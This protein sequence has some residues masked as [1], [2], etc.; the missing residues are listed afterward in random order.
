MVAYRFTM[1]A[2]AIVASFLIL[3]RQRAN[4]KRQFYYERAFKRGCL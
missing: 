2:L 3:I 1:I 4:I